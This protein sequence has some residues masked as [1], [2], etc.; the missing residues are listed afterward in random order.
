LIGIG[1]YVVLALLLTSKA[2]D[3]FLNQ[4]WVSLNY[5]GERTVQGFGINLFIHYLCFM[6]IIK[7]LA[8]IW[9]GHWLP[10]PHFV[11]LCTLVIVSLAWMGWIDDRWGDI[12]VKG[13]KGHFSRFFQKGEITTGLAKA[14]LGLVVAVLTS[15]PVSASFWQLILFVM[16]M[17]LS[18]HTFNLLDVR[19]GRAIKSFWLFS[20][21]VLPFSS[22]ESFCYLY[23]PSVISTM[24]LFHFDRRRLVM[25]GDAG[26][27][28][29]GGIFG[30]QLILEAP[31]GLVFF[32]T[33]AFLL[34][35]I[36]AE[37][38]SISLLIKKQWWLNKLD[39]WGIVNE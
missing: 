37:K 27:L 38:T 1:L 5:R 10:F 14:W 9:T 11:A 15:W 39:H 4:G 16:A 20:L 28:T 33:A 3:Y 23:L 24:I 13:F 8:L 18:M 29:L 26:S 32:W 17:V 12:S 22:L 31:V 21:S 6:F 2:Y 25:L 35:T 7:V 19:P 30:L 34:L 36:V